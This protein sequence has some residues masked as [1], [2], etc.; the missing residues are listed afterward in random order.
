MNFIS[1]LNKY[2]FNVVVDFFL[3]IS[4]NY[5]KG[6]NLIKDYI[7]IIINTIN[8]LWKILIDCIERIHNNWDKRT[9]FIGII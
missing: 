3:N 4:D 7:K 5:R 8:L 9:F 2:Y 6:N 1:K